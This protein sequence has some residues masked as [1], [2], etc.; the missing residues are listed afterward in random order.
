MARIA[1][2]KTKSDSGSKNAGEARPTSS[3]VLLALFN[4]LN[5]SGHIRDARF[6]DLFSGTG[7]V[8]MRALESGAASALAVES[9]RARSLRISKLFAEKY[10]RTRAAC[11][12]MDI[13]RALPRIERD[14][15]GSDGT[16]LKFDIIFC[17][18]PYGMGW[19]AALPELIKKHISI[20]A[21]DGVFV[22]ERSAREEPCDAGMSRDDR[23]YGD[24]VLSFYWMAKNDGGESN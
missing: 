17:D 10:D 24:T 14:I 23:T 11:I 3:K 18:P 13:R 15:C 7:G 12:C 4:I 16:G 21:P 1:A 5:T 20:L 19:G 9:D 6:L 2:K 8:A 22:M